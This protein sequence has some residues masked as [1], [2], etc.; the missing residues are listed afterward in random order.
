MLPGEA[1]LNSTKLVTVSAT[2]K[3][4]EFIIEGTYGDFKKLETEI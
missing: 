1:K 3:R 2:Q 4:L